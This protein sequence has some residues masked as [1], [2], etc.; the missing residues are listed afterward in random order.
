MSPIKQSSHIKSPLKL[1]EK[2]PLSEIASVNEE[3][4]SS[5]QPCF[6]DLIQIQETSA[7]L[8]SPIKITPKQLKFNSGDEGDEAFPTTL[9]RVFIRHS[10]ENHFK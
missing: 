4:E 9:S 6:F 5:T 7:R 3:E 8:E 2:Q 1:S 10:P